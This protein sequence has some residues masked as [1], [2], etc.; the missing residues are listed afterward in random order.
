MGCQDSSRRQQS[1]EDQD[2]LVGEIRIVGT[3]H[4][5]NPCMV[6][7]ECLPESQCHGHAGDADDDR[8]YSR[9]VAGIAFLEHPGFGDKSQPDN[10]ETRGRV[11]GHTSKVAPA[12]SRIQVE[13]IA[14]K[15]DATEARD[16]CTQYADDGARRFGEIE[17]ARVDQ[18]EAAQCKAHRSVRRHAAG[19][20]CLD[21]D[22]VLHEKLVQAEVQ[23]ENVLE[24][25]T[26]TDDQRDC[27]QHHRDAFVARYQQAEPGAADQEAQ[28]RVELH[29]YE[30]RIN[31]DQVGVFRV[32][33]G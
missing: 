9:Q 26:A 29:R 6:G 7:D 31:L 17:I 25:S 30:S 5:G 15:G 16:Y 33:A 12:V 22:V 28:R 10:D 1:A 23:P 3:Q 21:L 8:E 32:P 20:R 2:T 13:Q 18:C 24:K 19:M 11:Y 14:D 4:S 27:A